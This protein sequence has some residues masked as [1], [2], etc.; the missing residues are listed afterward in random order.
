MADK[1]NEEFL[2]PSL[3][4]FTGANED[5]MLLCLAKAVHRCLERS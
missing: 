2:L 3:G 1:Q 4:D 5:K